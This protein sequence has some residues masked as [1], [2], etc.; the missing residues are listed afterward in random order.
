MDHLPVPRKLSAPVTKVPFV[1]TRCYDGGPFLDYPWRL[2]HRS[3]LASTPGDAGFEFSGL[4]NVVPAEE[5]LSFFQTWLF[6]GLVCEFLGSFDASGVASRDIV[7]SVYKTVVKEEAGLKYITTRGLF[8]DTRQAWDLYKHNSTSEQRLATFRHLFRCLQIVQWMLYAPTSNFDHAV[9]FSIAS[10][11]ESLGYEV[12]TELAA[13]NFAESMHLAPLG[14]GYVNASIRTSMMNYGWCP[15]EIPKLAENYHSSL[16]T[17]HLL[18]K[19]DR[20]VPGRD[21]SGCS[22]KR[23]LVYNIQDKTYVAG[24]CEADCKTT[25]PLVEIKNEQTVS[26]LDEGYYPLLQLRKDTEGR[27]EVDVVRSSEKTPYIAISH[28]WADGLGNPHA[29][30]LHTCQ[31][32]R[33]FTLLQ[34]LSPSRKKSETHEH[35]PLMWLDTL[36]CPVKPEDAKTKSIKKMVDVYKNASHVLV[37]DR[38]LLQHHFGDL[39]VLEAMTRIFSSVWTTRLWT[40]QEGALA[41]SL[42]FQFEDKAISIWSLLEKFFA[43]ADTVLGFRGL[44]HDLVSE[45]RRLCQFFQ[46]R[47]PTWTIRHRLNL[48]DEALRYRSVSKPTDEPICVSTMLSLSV[49]QNFGTMDR[50][51]RMKS[52]WLNVGQHEGGIPS[53]IIFFAGARIDQ[54]GWRWAPLSF[55]SGQRGIDD[56]SRAHRWVNSERATIRLEGL[57]VR[58]L[59]VRYPGFKLRRRTTLPDKPWWGGLSRLPPGTHYFRNVADCTWHKVVE[60]EYVLAIRNGTADAWNAQNQHGLTKLLSDGNGAIIVQQQVESGGDGIGVYIVNERETGNGRELCVGTRYQLI[61]C[62]LPPQETLMCETAERLATKVGGEDVARRYA[63][64]SGPANHE[65][66]AA[67]ENLFNRIKAITKEAYGQVP[68]FMEAVRSCYGDD[69]IDSFWTLVRVWFYDDL[70]AES[71]SDD[72]LWCID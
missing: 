15:S 12:K 22:D 3:N 13:C 66:A 19:M 36:C 45:Y 69:H 63:E 44:L 37:L 47:N 56:D 51:E 17:L 1:G 52:V 32:R 57:Q 42:Y 28:V 55:M 62:P 43:E 11:A 50:K 26:I 24:H 48:L 20:S 61:Y 70:V 25:C 34:S 10:V 35:A 23:C 14:K 29:T 67:R 27:V 53:E 58:G 41:R 38:T 49:D 46:V 9:K 68:G 18:S 40:L 21:H 33:L 71:L 54:A 7:K 30:A 16:Q 8:A 60:K 5:Q 64:V 6:F 72:Q 31:L 65:Y 59:Q 2:L 39:D 4:D